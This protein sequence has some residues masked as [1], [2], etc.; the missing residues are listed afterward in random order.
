MHTIT[1]EEFCKGMGL[2]V[3]SADEG[4]EMQIT[5]SDI[6]RPGLELAGYFE[7]FAPGRVQVVGR[8]E[9]AYL[10]SRSTA[11][12]IKY[13]ETYFNKEFTCLIVCRGLDLPEDVLALAVAAK[14]PVL[15]SQQSTT[16]LVHRLIGYIDNLIAPRGTIHGVLMDIYGV[17]ILFTG[18]S[19]IGKSETA[20][21]LIKRGHRLVSDD[22]V[23]LCRVADNR[24]T[25]ESPKLIRYL[26]EMRGIGIIDVRSMYGVGSVIRQ[27]SIDLVIK[28]ERWDD[29][30]VYDRLGIS[31]EYEEMLGIKIPRITVPVAPGRNLAIIAEVAAR[32]FRLKAQG[33]NAAKELDRR[34]EMMM[35][36]RAEEL[37]PD[38]VSG[39]HF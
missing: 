21:E 8:S 35:S 37:D 26:M 14:K 2:S 13:M 1:V 22:A 10:T 34:M 25:G 27:K 7:Y 38:D 31:E 24:L 18:E 5:S 6:N 4:A 33:Y 23:E 12:Q 30:K 9:I 20:L 36:G 11:H 29:D 28:M 16:Q 17:G 3:V 39:M 15:S 19:G 32:N